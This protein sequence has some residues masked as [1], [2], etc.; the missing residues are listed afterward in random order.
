MTD[1][2]IRTERKQTQGQG[3][4]KMKAEIGTTCLA[5]KQLHISP[6]TSR[7]GRGAGTRFSLTTLEGTN[8]GHQLDVI[9]LAS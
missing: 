5:A 8:L 1:V 9:L 7:A 2:L 4:V 3:H 6:T